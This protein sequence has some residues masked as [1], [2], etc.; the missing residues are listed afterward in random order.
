MAS[1]G[2]GSRSADTHEMQAI[3]AMLLMST[4]GIMLENTRMDAPCGADSGKSAWRTVKPSIQGGMCDVREF[5]RAGSDACSM[6][7]AVM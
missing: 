5:G 6:R 4:L 7:A 3:Q 1:R 2:L